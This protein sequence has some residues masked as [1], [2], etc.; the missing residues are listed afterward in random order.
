MKTKFYIIQIAIL[1]LGLVFG[2]LAFDCYESGKWITA[3]LFLCLSVFMIILN[4]R[5][6][7]QS[8]KET[9]QILQAINH[10]DFSLFPDKK[11]NDPLKQKA[12]DLYY[13]EK[14]KNTDVLSFKILYENILNQL[15][16]GIMILK[17]N[18][19]DWEVFYSNPK[20]I[21]IL[22]VPKY[23]RWR[24]YEEKSPEFFK[25]IKDT[26]YRES[27]DFMEVSINQAGF[28]T[29]SL[30]T[31]RL[32][33]P[34]EDF[35][36]ISLESVQK[37]IE[38]KEKMAWNNL[39]KVISHELLNTLTPINSLI[40]NMEYITDQ[41][42]ISRDD[43]EEIKESLKIVNNKSE[44]LLNFINNYRQV[45]ELPKPKLQK[46]SIRPVIEKVLRLMESEF[47]NKS[48]TVSTNIRDYM[49]MADEKMLERSLINLLTNALHAVEDLDNGKIKINTDQQNTRTVIQVEDNGIGIS[50]QISD[51]IFLP[52][53][54]TRNSGSGIGLT[55][56]K[57]IME[58][59]N[60]YIN[61]RKQQQGSVFELWFT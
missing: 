11:Q 30:R 18:T 52:F 40:R 16:I 4:I 37:I 27:Q 31:T 44:Q 32:E 36:I 28:Q 9:E 2:I 57:S 61:F 19:N 53:F 1:L 58:A 51:K 46:I 60:G 49:V 5:N 26:D 35:C 34:S 22:K 20:F 10:K 59:H 48:I 15:D 6:A 47:Q 33:T 7:Q 17:E 23:N 29:Y 38:R 41:E 50:D 43:Q 55:L 45:A 54:T 21:E 42:E 12:V 25:L 39:M 24:L 8:G 56:T 13:Q 3:L 14:E